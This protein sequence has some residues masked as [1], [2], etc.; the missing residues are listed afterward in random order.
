ML[1]PDVDDATIAALQ[2]AM[3]RLRGELN[4]A[5]VARTLAELV[6]QHAWAVSDMS[7]AGMTEAEAAD[8]LKAVRP[9]VDQALAEANLGGEPETPPADPDPTVGA[10]PLEI[11]FKSEKDKR[12]FRAALKKAAGKGNGLDVGALRMLD[13]D[14]A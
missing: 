10:F 5:D 11:V 4:L 1:G 6:E 7:V 9:T 8:L 3:N 13:G 12:R 14:S 2:I